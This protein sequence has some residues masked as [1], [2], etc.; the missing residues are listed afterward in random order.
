MN[1]SNSSQ[2]PPG[3]IQKT[4]QIVKAIFLFL[5]HFYIHGT[6][7]RVERLASS[8]LGM[9]VS[10][11]WPGSIWRLLIKLVEFPLRHLRD[12]VFKGKISDFKLVYTFWK[13]GWLGRL[14]LLM[15]TVGGLTVPA[16]IILGAGNGQKTIPTPVLAAGLVVFA[17]AYAFATAAAWYQPFW[18]YVLLGFYLLWFASLPG[19]SLA[20]TP[21]MALP[22]LW[23][24]FTGWLKTRS[25]SG[26]WKYLWLALLCGVVSYHTLGALGLSLLL[27]KNYQWASMILLAAGYF[28]LTALPLWISRKAP[29]RSL[30]GS[31]FFFFGTLLV[32]GVFYCLAALQDLQIT[33]EYAL[34]S[35]SALLWIVDLI[36]MW[37]GATM[38]E[39][40]IKAGSWWTNESV[41]LVTKRSARWLIPLVWALTALFAWVATDTTDMQVLWISYQ[42]GLFKWAGTWDIGFYFSVQFQIYA[43]LAALV[44]I[45]ISL[46]LHRFTDDLLGVVNAAWIAVFLAVVG[47]YKSLEGFYN[48]N[49]NALPTNWWLVLTLV[50]GLV[51]GMVK[52]AEDYWKSE[53]PARHFAI[54][55]LLGLLLAASAVTLGSSSMDVATDY[56]FYSFLGIVYLGA[57]M[58]VYEVV[59]KLGFQPLER[60]KLI[61]LVIIGGLSALIPLGINPVGDWSML[62]AP[63]VWLLVLLLWGNNL[64]RFVSWGDAALAGGTMAIGFVTFWMYPEPIPLPGYLVFIHDLQT[65]YNA[66]INS[67]GRPLLKE[68]QLWLTLA[69]LL[70]GLLVGSAA[71]FGKRW[72]ISKKVVVETLK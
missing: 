15:V 17:L 54:M 21:M 64:A 47:Y 23:L 71:Y 4:K 37:L 27:T 41:G 40:A 5:R 12:N 3:M 16:V 49:L 26:R 61:V 28:L 44:V 38:V 30:P 11:G 14:E 32:V 42:L 52:A 59:Q 72:V 53:N 58:L 33:A 69:A 9:A 31:S 19:F 66:I 48:Y 39:G 45:G 67:V 56:T 2:N 46:L 63:L 36:W 13:R 65:R 1:D 29:P 55:A 51:W 22:A 62:L 6:L 7:P 57:P 43:S 8:R 35:M 20:F 34:V 18:V 68:G 50:F 25:D 10:Q 24:L 60:K 70:V